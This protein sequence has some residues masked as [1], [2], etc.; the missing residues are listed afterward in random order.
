MKAKY[1]FL[2][3]IASSLFSYDV[4][5]IAKNKEVWTD[6]VLSL[7]HQFQLMVGFG[8]AADYLCLYKASDYKNYSN[9]KDD[10]NN[11]IGFKAVL[12]NPNCGTVEYSSPWI[13]KSEQASSDSDL[14]ME[15]FNLRVKTY[16]KRRSKHSKSVWNF[17]A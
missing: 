3:F 7:N 9:I 8:R 17:N 1:L 4:N 11:S 12:D 15:M 16:S 6:P 10:N 5:S 13:F 2:I 14:V